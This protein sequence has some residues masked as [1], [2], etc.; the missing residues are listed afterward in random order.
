VN[1]YVG[2]ELAFGLQQWSL[3]NCQCIQNH[4]SWT[5]KMLQSNNGITQQDHSVND[6][7]NWYEVFGW[8]LF[9]WHH[10]SV[11]MVKMLWFHVWKAKSGAWCPTE[12]WSLPRPNDTKSHYLHWSGVYRSSSGFLVS[13]TLGW[14]FQF[15]EGV[16]SVSL[17]QSCYVFWLSLF[18]RHGHIWGRFKE[19]SQSHHYFRVST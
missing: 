15:L 11:I 3:Q 10:L 4:F 17:T 12:K 6:E 14:K 8:L 16:S 19:M 13:W 7:D 1:S 5:Q 18:C 9:W 2:I